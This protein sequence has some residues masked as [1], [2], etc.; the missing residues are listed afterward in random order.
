[1]VGGQ[2]LIELALAVIGIVTLAYVTGAVFSWLN[3][4]LVGRS[5]AYQATRVAAAMQP[6]QPGAA[7]GKT[8][9][10]ERPMLSLIGTPESTGKGTPGPANTLVPPCTAAK[11]F[12]TRAE[13]FFTWAGFYAKPESDANDQGNKAVARLQALKQNE[14]TY[15]QAMQAACTDPATSATSVCDGSIPGSVCAQKNTTC[16]KKDTICKQADIYYSKKV[17]ACKAWPGGPLCWFYTSLWSIYT[18][19]C[20]PLQTACSG[21]ETQCGTA[22]TTAQTACTD[23]TKAYNDLIATPMDQLLEEIRSMNELADYY[24]AQAEHNRG[25]AK[26]CLEI[27]R[28]ACSGSGPTAADFE[29]CPEHPDSASLP[30]MGGM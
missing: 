23:A 17:S 16:S 25:I 9:F 2:V 11:T 10:Y 20:P 3:G 19:M 12:Y 30:P 26:A 5:A 4:T 29:A 14:A 27:G 15:Q 7:P 18:T 6:D 24:R 22:C 1:L 21:L 8:D 13:M 28:Q